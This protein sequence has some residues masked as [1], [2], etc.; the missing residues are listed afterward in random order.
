MRGMEQAKPCS[1]FLSRPGERSQRISTSTEIIS[2][3]ESATLPASYEQAQTALA[4]CS[5]VDECKEWADKS[6]ALRSYARQSKNEELEKMSMRIKARAIRRCG[7][8][9]EEIDRPEQ[10]GRPSKNGGGMSPVSKRSAASEAGLS[11]DQQKDAIRVARI[12][13]ESFERQID[14]DDPPT[15]TALAEQGK[16]QRKPLI[17][18]GG[19]APADFAASTRGQG[20]LREFA[21]ACRQINWKTVIR[22][23]MPKELESMRQHS[24][25]VASSMEKLQEL[26]DD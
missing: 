18:L 24:V 1:R 21:D 22:G 11:I 26:L 19:R 15:V 20:S 10:G 23:A 8:L 17:D 12:P 13:I 25:R 16:R 3:A 7:E 14:S 9:I 2:R 5:R 6:E 4:E